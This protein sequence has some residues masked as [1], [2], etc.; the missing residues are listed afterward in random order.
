MRC[1]F[2]LLF[3]ASPW[4]VGLAQGQEAQPP[5]SQ[6]APESKLIR[7][8][9]ET[10]HDAA[11]NR[12]IP[13]K[14]YLP[15]HPPAA[16]PAPAGP[17]PTSDRPAEELASPGKFPLVIF[18]HGLGGSRENYRYIGENL[19]R[20]GY[21][22]ILPTHEGS[23]TRALVDRSRRPAG[24]GR[25][26]GSNF[27][28]DS[29]SSPENLRNR[30]ADVSFVID[31]IAADAELAPLADLGRIAVAGH[32]FG[33]YTSLAVA[34]M[35]V[36]IPGNPG[37]SFR[38]P[39]VKAAIA[40][41]PQGSG[42]MRV[43]PGAWGSIDIPVLLLTGTRDYGQGARAAAWRRE[44]F[45]SMK[46]AG[47]AKDAWLLVITDATHMTFSGPVTRLF[48][49]NSDPA[50]SDHHRLILDATTS[51]LD[52][53]LKGDAAAM[54]WLEEA[55][56]HPRADCTVEWTRGPGAESALPAG[57]RLVPT[58]PPRPVGSTRQ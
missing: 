38:D 20:H 22:V 58:V 2:L 3:L 24:E 51:F 26:A 18:S 36:E 57:S 56:K 39:R 55:L 41:S 9:L 48:R 12:D 45:D 32:S 1:R 44:P 25:A 7:T 46:A 31:R 40:M 27:L 50:P 16:H 5:A 35:K 30:P 8:Q 13:V 4:L 33:A 34:G 53:H 6:P 17:P 11:R 49:S 47:A 29:T 19:A 42:A 21:L 23:D 43:Q 14:I 10:W 37:L 54:G 52:V 15:E 28:A